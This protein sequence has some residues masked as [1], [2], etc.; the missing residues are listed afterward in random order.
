[1]EQEQGFM[2]DY[3]VVLKDLES[4]LAKIPEKPGYV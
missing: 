3:N 1:M 4:D 2:I